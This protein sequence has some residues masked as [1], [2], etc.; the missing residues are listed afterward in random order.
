M[1]PL[2]KL[3]TFTD[4]SLTHLHL[5]WWDMQN[6]IGKYSVQ[7]YSPRYWW[8][9]Q[10]LVVQLCEVSLSNPDSWNDL[11]YQ[12]HFQF[13]DERLVEYSWAMKQIARLG[14]SD[15]FLDVGCVMNTPYTLRKLMDRFSDIHFLNL[16]S[17]PLA[18]QG[19]ISFHSQDIRSCDLP[20]SSFD[21]IT[22]ISTL[23]HVGGD[24]QYNDFS[25]NGSAEINLD[26][27]LE[28]QQ[29]LWKPA[30]AALLK[31]I[32]LGG[33][34]LVTMPCGY[35][36]QGVWQKGEYR[37]GIEELAE[38]HTLAAQFN[39]QVKLTVMKKSTMGWEETSVDEMNIDR[40][41]QEQLRS[42]GADVVVLV[43]TLIE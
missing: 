18:M 27:N 38:F 35:E 34:L 2:K 30:F 16:V 8:T 12:S 10:G 11:I 15:R 6:S 13:Y 41:R 33:L 3:L 24:N 28:N 20:N 17:E 22:C 23:E 26:S 43:E 1:N 14:N 19:R 32:K 40:D 31:L 21:C 7:P 5:K 29:G 42:F 39:R 25:E 4:T 9:R 36:Q 37:L